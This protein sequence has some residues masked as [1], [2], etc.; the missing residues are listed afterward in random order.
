M[1]KSFHHALFFLFG[2]EGETGVGR[3]NFHKNQPAN[4]YILFKES[5]MVW[6]KRK[7]GSGLIGRQ[8]GYLE[9]NGVIWNVVGT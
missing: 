7:S 3:N 6:K 4:Q 8:R 9:H 1:F 5:T 2:V